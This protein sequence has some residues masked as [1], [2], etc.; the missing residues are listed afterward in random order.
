M[1]TSFRK[2]SEKELK[3]YL[4]WS[5]TLIIFIVLIIPSGCRH[6]NH[7]SN[8]QSLSNLNHSSGN[9]GETAL[10]INISSVESLIENPTPFLEREITLLG[11][12]KEFQIKKGPKGTSILELTIN[13]GNLTKIPPPQ[14]PSITR[15]K[16]AEQLDAIGDKMLDSVQR[17]ELTNIE[18]SK[19]KDISY[20]LKIDGNRIEALSHFFRSKDLFE[21][22]DEVQSI[23]NGYLK[24]GDAFFAFSEIVVESA[25]NVMLEQIEIQSV[26]T[27]SVPSTN[28]FQFALSKVSEEL[29]LVAEELIKNR[30]N[31]VGQNLLLENNEISNN[32]AYSLL[33]VGE[34]ME[35]KSWE[36]RKNQN[37]VAEK[38]FQV[39]SAGFTML[40]EGMNNL[41]D[42]F[43]N[44]G[45]KLTIKVNPVLPTII[46]TSRL[47]CAY[48]GYN[49]HVIRDCEKKLEQLG[50]DGQ[51]T[52]QGQLIQGSLME[53]LNV[54]W[55][56]MKSVTVDDLTIDLAYDDI[57]ATWRNLTSFYDWVKE[58]T[59]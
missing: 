12:V 41:Y 9:P 58:T 55:V 44:L 30:Y 25:P 50:V 40:G 45:N 53:E 48:I 28:E 39:V 35:A 26:T 4:K 33:S 20:N 46:E 24:L 29:S 51:L 8:F 15:L 23:A 13:D 49:N 10:P 6:P 22:G 47:K 17:I 31:I 54:L 57:P 34:L 14:S 56:K 18:P 11:T 43:R 7:S 52:I 36:S 19:F 16:L 5:I 2:N 37:E 32:K 38:Q 1:S 27:N 21:V 42:G 59:N 3:N